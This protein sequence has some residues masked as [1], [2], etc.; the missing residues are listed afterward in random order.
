MFFQDI[1]NNIDSR[2]VIHH[3]SLKSGTTPFL[4]SPEHLKGSLFPWQRLTN[5]LKFSQDSASCFQYFYCS[6][7]VHILVL[8]LTMS[9]FTISEI[10]RSQVLANLPH[11]SCSDLFVQQREDIMCSACWHKYFRLKPQ[12]KSIHMPMSKIWDP[13]HRPTSI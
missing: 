4:P 10:L 6:N 2:P 7:F 3:Y 1:T 5:N 12:W 13:D 9:A 11:L 8:V